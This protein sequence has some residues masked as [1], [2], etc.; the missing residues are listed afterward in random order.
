MG[1][2]FFMVFDHLAIGWVTAGILDTNDDRFIHLVRDDGALL[3]FP[4]I[5]F[6]LGTLACRRLEFT[7]ILYS[8]HS[9]DILSE[10]S[11]AVSA[12][13]FFCQ[14]KLIEQFVAFATHFVILEYKFFVREVS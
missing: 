13:K 12:I 9:S 8:E 5:A 10:E 4:F 14:L 7:L 3:D 2:I 11:Q 6:H 1:V